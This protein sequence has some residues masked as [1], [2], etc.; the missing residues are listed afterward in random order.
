MNE[1]KIYN[2]L[3]INL[4]DYNNYFNIANGFFIPSKLKRF[5]GNSDEDTNNC[6]L[7]IV[8]SIVNQIDLLI[9]LRLTWA[10][11]ISSAK[12][13]FIELISE[14]RKTNLKKAVY[15]EI[16]FRLLSNTFPEFNNRQE[17]TSNNISRLGFSKDYSNI[18]SMLCPLAAGYLIASSWNKLEIEHKNTNISYFDFL[19]SKISRINETQNIHSNKFNELSEEINKLDQKILNNSNFDNLQ[20]ELIQSTKQKLEQQLNTNNI[21]NQSLTTIRSLSENNKSSIDTLITNFELNKNKITELNNISSQSR[22]EINDLTN[23][24]TQLNDELTKL[25]NKVFTD[26]H[27]LSQHGGKI[28]Q[29]EQ[30]LQL[31]SEAKADKSNVYS[32]QEI[33]NRL[34]SHNTSSNNL[35]V[36]N[37]DNK[38]PN[39]CKQIGMYA[40]LFSANGA[41]TG[42]RRGTIINLSTYSNNQN[43]FMQIFVSENEKIF[44]RKFNGSSFS[45]WQQFPLMKFENNIL[46]IKL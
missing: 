40:G 29:L 27:N 12:S 14:F 43:Y 21:F 35:A 17:L 45:E 8:G 30:N 18:E 44:L 39:D 37:G 20:E 1:D 42:Q 4:D 32:K 33:D 36:N 31:V 46:K 22:E 6:F 38:S 2:W 19:E 10:I 23:K 15:E 9:G 3:D 7:K 41:P 16:N 25:T 28:L 34:R 11:D 26:S 5:Y 13:E 24:N